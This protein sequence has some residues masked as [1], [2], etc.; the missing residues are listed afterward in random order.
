MRRDKYCTLICFT[1]KLSHATYFDS[2][3]ANKKNYEN[4]KK[5]MD[6]ALNGY[7]LAE[8]PFKKK[9]IVD[10]KHVFTHKTEFHC[11]KQ[12]AGSAK[13]AYYALHQMKAFERDQQNLTLPSTHLKQWA[14]NLAR[15]QDDNL[16][17]S[18][19]HIQ[20]QFASIIVHDVNTRGGLLRRHQ[21]T[22]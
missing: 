19:F 8:G 16:E 22:A 7:A 20:Q 3:S 17:E 5:F 14:S 18:F 13:D 4:I 6:D 12:P 9:R 10:H 15:I 1:P 21:S 11:V 2:G